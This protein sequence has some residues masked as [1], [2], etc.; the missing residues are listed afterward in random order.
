ML[1]HEIDCLDNT[2][3]SLN[4]FKEQLQV[5]FLHGFKSSSFLGYVL[6]PKIDEYCS[7]IF[8]NLDQVKDRGEMR[9]LLGAYCSYIN[10]MHAWLHVR[11]PWGFG[12]AFPKLEIRLAK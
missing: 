10:M 11:F 6:D 12:C 8:E 9:E 2:T 1:Y 7:A 5:F 3:I 4:D